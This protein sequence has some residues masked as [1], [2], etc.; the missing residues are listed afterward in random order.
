VIGY[1]LLL[2]VRSALENSECPFANLPEKR[3]GRWGQGL[4]A[5]KMKDCRWLKPVLVG[6]FEFREWTA[7]DICGIRG[8]WPCGMIKKATAVRRESVQQ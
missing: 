3:P 5:A 1:D 2:L 6:Q 4:T 7:D 8:S